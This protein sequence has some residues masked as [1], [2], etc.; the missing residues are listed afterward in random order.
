SMNRLGERVRRWCIDHPLEYALIGTILIVGASY[1]VAFKDYA[2]PLPGMLLLAAF[3]M[4]FLLYLAN[5][6]RK[7][8]R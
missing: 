6:A 2:N 4:V 1:G 3:S 7:R 8:Q 5:K